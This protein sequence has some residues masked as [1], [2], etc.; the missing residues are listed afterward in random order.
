M[1]IERGLG[2]FN[3]SLLSL[4]SSCLTEGETSTDIGPCKGRK[5]TRESGTFFIIDTNKNSVMT[6]TYP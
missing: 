6:N 1:D 4:L 5:S 2:S 3:T